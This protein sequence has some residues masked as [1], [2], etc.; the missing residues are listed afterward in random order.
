MKQNMRKV[1]LIMSMILIAIEICTAMMTVSASAATNMPSFQSNSYT[2][3]VANNTIKVY[4]DSLCR[5]RGTIWPTVKAY[6]SY[7]DPGDL[8]KILASVNSGTVIKVEFPTPNGKRVGFIRA[9][10]VFL[11][12]ISPTEG[13]HSYWPGKITVYST[14]SSRTKWGEIWK[15]DMCYVYG[16]TKNNRYQ[17]LF[18][19]KS[20]NR[21]YKLG[22]IASEDLD[23]LKP[24]ASTNNPDPKPKEQIVK[25]ANYNL[26]VADKAALIK[27]AYRNYEGARGANAY[28]TIVKQFDVTRNS[29]YRRSSNATFCNIY[30]VDIMVAMGLESS[31]SHWIDSNGK[32][33]KPYSKGSHELTANATYIWLRNHGSSYGWK[34]VSAKQA[35]QRANSGYP[36]LAVWYNPNPRGSGHIAVVIPE[37]TH[38]QY[39]GN[40]NV[41][42]SQAGASNLSVA[43]ASQGFGKSKLASIVYYTHN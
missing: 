35:Q 5:S 41:I 30:S 3:F 34:K 25:M 16:K 33:V 40:N 32:P 6:N 13:G 18:E 39:F 4:K 38:H 2:E 10:D 14:Y 20:R 23:R 37:D 17:I 11:M 1:S 19:A 29:R 15:N 43:Y 28:T 31:F 7:I 24:T 42:I 26:H 22:W 9:S 12:K 27:P 8:C 36:T 21:K